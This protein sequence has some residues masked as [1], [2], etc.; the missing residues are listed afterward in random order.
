MDTSQLFAW[1]RKPKRYIIEWTW[2]NSQVPALEMRLNARCGAAKMRI[3]ASEIAELEMGWRQF[4]AIM[5]RE[6]RKTA[7]AR[8]HWQKYK[9]I[10]LS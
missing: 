6:L 7:Q 5:L 2:H 9:T 8:Q 3:K 1:L 4:L 10:D